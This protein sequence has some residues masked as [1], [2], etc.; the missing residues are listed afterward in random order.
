L[1]G[2]GLGGNVRRSRVKQYRKESVGK[3]SHEKGN[4]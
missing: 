3:E 4:T 2:R 1:L